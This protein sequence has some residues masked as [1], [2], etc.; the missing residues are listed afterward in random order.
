MRQER[1]MGYMCHENRDRDHLGRRGPVS[2]AEGKGNGE[3]VRIIYVCIKKP[4]LY[5]KQQI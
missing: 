5:A 2:Q 3:T 4:I 1:V